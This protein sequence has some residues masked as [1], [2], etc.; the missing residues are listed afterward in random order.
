MIMR[1]ICFALVALL[2]T[3][4]Y[5]DSNGTLGT[6]TVVS[7][8]SVTLTGGPF[9][10]GAGAGSADNSTAVANFVGGFT[11]NEIL[12]EG[13][14]TPLIGGTFGSEADIIV[15]DPAGGNLTWQNPLGGGFT[16]PLTYS[17]SQPLPA[18]ISAAGAWNF[19]FIE[20]FSDGAGAD[21][22]SS[23]VTVTLQDVLLSLIHI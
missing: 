10:H 23:N 8:E 4:A 15:T 18:P 21:S 5:A 3:S 12:I 14:L 6:T 2:T 1:F 7:S 19:E 16:T 13:T 20:S 11:A 9:S 17:S 22:E